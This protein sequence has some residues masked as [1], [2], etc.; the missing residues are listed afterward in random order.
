MKVG[1]S[2]AGHCRTF[3]ALDEDPDGCWLV[4][5]C[6]DRDKQPVELRNKERS[7]RCRYSRHLR[8]A[9]ISPF[10]RLKHVDHAF[11]TGHLNAMA[12][13]VDEHIIGIAAGLDL[14]HD[15]P[16]PAG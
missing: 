8:Q 7:P 5:G 3:M 6:P 14:A 2:A 10:A 15:L 11:T 12:L 1:T 16:T 13:V 9:H 4:R